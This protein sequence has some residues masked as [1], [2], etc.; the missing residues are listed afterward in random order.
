MRVSIRNLDWVKIF[1]SFVCLLLITLTVYF[2]TESLLLFSLAILLALFLHLL[3]IRF[4]AIKKRAKL[5]R[6]ISA[7]G[8]F[9]EVGDFEQ[10]SYIK[11]FGYY[12][13]EPVPLAIFSDAKGIYVRIYRFSSSKFGTFMISWNDLFSIKIE[14]SGPDLQARLVFCKKSGVCEN[15]I[16]IPWNKKFN[17]YGR[18]IQ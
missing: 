6:F 10:F 12:N 18:V 7:Y 11:G 2:L 13:D 14:Q 5:K 1:H 17:N 3:L 8:R 9:V 4:L 16:Y 15:I